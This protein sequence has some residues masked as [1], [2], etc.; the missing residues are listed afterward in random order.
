VQGGTFSRANRLW[1]FSIFK[2]YN[3]RK[4]ASV[5]ACYWLINQVFG[6]AYIKNVLL[7]E[8]G[9]YFYIEKLAMSNYIFLL[10]KH[11][12]IVKLFK[13]LS[14]NLDM[15]LSFSSYF[16]LVAFVSFIFIYLSLNTIPCLAKQELKKKIFCWTIVWK[17][18][19]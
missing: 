12:N 14:T 16:K 3:Y 10:M 13:T 7:N 5:N 19:S 2:I 18:W 4:V 9:F 1:I 17:F 11:Y 15:C 8:M 6:C